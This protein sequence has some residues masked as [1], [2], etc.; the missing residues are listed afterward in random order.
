MKTQHPSV[1]RIKSKK[2]HRRN[3]GRFKES[4]QLASRA[5]GQRT[6]AILK[7]CKEFV[8]SKDGIAEHVKQR[9]EHRRSVISVQ[10]PGKL[11]DRGKQH[12]RRVFARQSPPRQR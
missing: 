9:T 2:R 10:H 3:K 1:D 12:R 11:D 7:H 8:K 4:R 5:V 6:Q